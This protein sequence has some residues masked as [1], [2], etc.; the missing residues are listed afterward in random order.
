[1]IELADLLRWVCIPLALALA[2]LCT[3]SAVHAPG[4]AQRTRFVVLLGYAVVSVGGQLDALGRPLSWRLP[5]LL[6]V[7]AAAVAGTAVYVFDQRRTARATEGAAR[8]GRHLDDLGGVHRAGRA[9]RRRGRA[10][11]RQ[12]QARHDPPT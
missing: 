5:L 9:A 6:A 12:E 3:A 11:H 2:V 8:G 7:T 10:G 1:M 4:W